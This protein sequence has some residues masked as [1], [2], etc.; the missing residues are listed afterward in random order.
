MSAKADL[1]TFVIGMRQLLGQSG[2]SQ[3]QHI[4]NFECPFLRVHFCMNVPRRH[5]TRHVTLRVFSSVPRNLFAVTVSQRPSANR[6]R[7]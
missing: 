6:L 3:N 5:M 2:L 4:L 7:H 1:L